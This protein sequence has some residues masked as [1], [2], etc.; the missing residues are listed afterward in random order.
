MRTEGRADGQRF[1]FVNI[2]PSAPLGNAC[3]SYTRYIVNS[4]S[5]MSK[6]V[7]CTGGRLLWDDRPIHRHMAPSFFCAVSPTLDSSIVGS[8]CLAVMEVA[9]RSTAD[10]YMIRGKK[11]YYGRGANKHSEAPHMSINSFYTSLEN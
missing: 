3:N 10:V 8:Q 5:R 11:A 9:G 6:I 1:I 2:V 4:I 7:C